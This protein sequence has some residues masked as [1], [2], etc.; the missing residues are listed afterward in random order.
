MDWLA[1]PAGAHRDTVEVPSGRLAR[2][3]MGPAD[4][5]RVLL[6][7]GVTGSKEDF[8]LM[9]P[10][11]ASAG[12]RVEAVD[13]AGQY[14]SSAAGP[15]HT[16]QG[17]G[18]YTLRL[19]A[20]D[21]LALIGAGSAPVHLLGYSYAGT[22]AAQ[23]AVDHPELVASLTLLSA[24]PVP[25]QSLRRFRILGPLTWI[26][27]GRVIGDALVWALHHNLGF[28]ERARARLVRTRL[29]LTRTSSVGD[30]MSLM[31]HIPDLVAPL[32]ACGV[33]VLVCAGSG[34]IWP[35]RLH[36]RYAMSCGARFR[37]FRSGHAVCETAP[38]QLAGTMLS[39]FAGLEPGVEEPDAAGPVTAPL[40]PPSGS[41]GRPRTGADAE[42]SPP[43]PS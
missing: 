27:P 39:L 38:H 30:V 8:T 17:G 29:R 14:E 19:F 21:L 33:P 6:V 40:R 42:P 15:E 16:R 13:M 7:P 34:D 1:L 43:R 5:P 28:S 2:A 3:W 4:G 20:D 25:G 31:K 24:P 11:L 22:V 32:R 26:L 41:G 23:V 35:L 9:M 12:Y 18:R 10:V 37:R 36:R